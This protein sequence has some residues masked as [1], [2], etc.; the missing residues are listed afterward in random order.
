MDRSNENIVYEE[1]GE[2][3]THIKDVNLKILSYLDDKS[4]L[5]TCYVNKKAK[6]LCNNEDF[7][8]NKFIY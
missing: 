8:R 4:L 6:K 1:N 3:L 2:Y 5:K 7:W